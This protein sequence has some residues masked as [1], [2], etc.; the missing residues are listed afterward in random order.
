M[1]DL[2]S[3]L[4]SFLFAVVALN[5]LCFFE[6]VQPIDDLVS[7]LNSSRIRQS[8]KAC[9]SAALSVFEKSTDDN[10]QS[11]Q[12]CSNDDGNDIAIK[13]FKLEVSIASLTPE[14]RFKSDLI[15]AQRKLWLLNRSLLI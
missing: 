2:K 4:L 14:S 5:L 1:Q 6:T 7:E 3:R 11:S 12:K 8:A 15:P 9:L 13:S 10:G